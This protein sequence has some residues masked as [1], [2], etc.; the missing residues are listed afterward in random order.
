GDEGEGGGGGGDRGGGGEGGWGGEGTAA[1]SFPPTCTRARKVCSYYP[2][3][4]HV[5]LPPAARAGNVAVVRA[6]AGA[7]A[8][9]GVVYA[10]LLHEPRSDGSLEKVVSQGM[11]GKTKFSFS[12]RPRVYYIV[13]F[14]GCGSKMLGGWLYDRGRQLVTKVFHFHDPHPPERLY[15]TTVGMYAHNTLR[16]MRY[17]EYKFP[18][19]D[20]SFPSSGAEVR[21]IDSYRVVVIFRDPAEALISRYFRGH[22]R[23]IPRALTLTL[24][25]LREPTCSYAEEAGDRLG[26]ASFFYNF[27]KPGGGGRPRRNYPVV[28]INYH[29]IWDNPEAV[30]RALGLP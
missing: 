12:K 9:A 23:Q 5:L 28:C 13:S 14:G 26:L 18:E 15:Q 7:G 4:T 11:W 20:F 21:D 17:R 27:C 24:I 29:K 8:E 19:G 30:V 3:C 6:G 1:P 2:E 22:S 25:C 10:R 16:N